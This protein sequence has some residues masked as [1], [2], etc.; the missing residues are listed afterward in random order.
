M[1]NHQ[2]TLIVKQRL[3]E[4]ES[5]QVL[6]HLFLPAASPPHEASRGVA[7]EVPPPLP[8][9]SLPPL[10]RSR[11]AA[12]AAGRQTWC[13]KPQTATG[14]PQRAVISQT[15]TSSASF[16][17]VRAHHFL[18]LSPCREAETRSDAPLSPA[19]YQEVAH[20]PRGSSVLPLRTPQLAARPSLM[21]PGDVLIAPNQ[22]CDG[23]QTCTL[24]V[25][26]SDR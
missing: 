18:L 2:P 24:V 4:E 20:V 16:S 6:P 23:R 13:Q 7:G 15:C 10:R 3:E 26:Q 9:S 22:A 21:S 17:S 14:R 8:V 1:L 19:Q 12:A 25:S 5:V 11:W